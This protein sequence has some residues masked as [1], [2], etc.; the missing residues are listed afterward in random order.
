MA[1]IWRSDWSHFPVTDPPVKAAA[2]SQSMLRDHLRGN[3]G[4]SEPI[5]ISRQTAIWVK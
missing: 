2:G 1:S 4:V 3:E 5:E